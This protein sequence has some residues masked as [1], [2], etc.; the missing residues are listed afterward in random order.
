MTRSPT[1]NFLDRAI[2]HS[3]LTQREVAARAGF[4]KPNMISMMKK[5]DTKVPIE[6]IPALAKVCGVDAKDFLR[7]A[8]KEYH[9][10]IWEI[11]SEC[12][13]KPA[14]P[15]DET[16]LLLLSIV[17]PKQ[18]VTLELRDGNFLLSVF[19]YVFDIRRQGKAGSAPTATSRR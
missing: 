2:D 10:G 17:D 12:F 7:A 19:E 6:R 18:E 16:I 8:F 5:G 4:A 11:L 15:R 1:A 14:S 13:G 9:P 3:G